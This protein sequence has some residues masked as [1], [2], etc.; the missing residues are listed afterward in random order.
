MIQRKSAIVVFVGA[1]LALLSAVVLLAAP[2]GY[3]WE[4]LPLLIAL[5]TVLRWGAYG[6]AAAAAVSFVGLILEL[7]QSDK[8]RVNISVAVASILFG[9]V[10]FSIPAGFR[11]GPQIPPIHDITTDTNNPPE[12]VAVVSM[13]TPGRTV[14]EGPSIAVQQQE[15]YPDIQPIVLD[16]PAEEVFNKAVA[17]VE[18]MGWDL[19]DADPTA[20]RVEATDTTFWFGFKDD[21][22][23]RVQSEG[24]GSRMDVRS[25]S[26]VGGSD[27]GKNAERIREFVSVFKSN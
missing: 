15:A 9:L 23:I 7:L 6:A 10:I 22:V 25:L 20:G 27:V 5:L 4:V 26:R 16:A 17:T 8:S 3:R 1:G 14:Y 12:F 11:L 13:N 21:V 19:V 2:L 18:E 24:M